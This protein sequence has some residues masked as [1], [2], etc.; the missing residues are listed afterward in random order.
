M[1]RIEEHRG[2][3]DRAVLLCERGVSLAESYGDPILSGLARIFRSRMAIDQGDEALAV[4]NFVRAVEFAESVEGSRVM[5]SSSAEWL[6]IIAARNGDVEPLVRIA[7]F[8]E[9]Y[10]EADGRLMNPA[11][12]KALAVRAATAAIA[13][14]GPSAL[15]PYRT[16]G[17]DPSVW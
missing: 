3:I 8:T 1:R 16:L 6:G 5:F 14:P 7:A 15:E 17:S 12:V 13:L 2:Q 4:N 9:V 11:A 10:R